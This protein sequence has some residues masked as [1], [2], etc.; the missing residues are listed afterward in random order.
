MAQE[1]RAANGAPGSYPSRTT[2]GRNRARDTR[3]RT[4]RGVFFV[5]AMISVLTTVGIILSLLGETWE[6]FQLV[7]IW[8]FLTET[9]WTPLFSNQQFGIWALVSATIVTSVIAL[10]IAVPLGIIAAIYL[11]EFASERAREILKPVLE[12]VAGIPTVVFGFFALLFVTPLLRNA[13]TDLSTFNSLSAGLVMGIMILPLVASL[14]E[15]AMA[16]VPLALREGA[17]GLGG[18]RFEVATRV[19]L[20]AALSGV[21]ASVILAASRAVGETMIVAIA[22]GQTPKFTFNPTETVETMTTYIVQV[23]LGDTP[24]GSLAY[25]TIFAVGTT[26]F[27]ITFAMN[28]FSFWF[29][30]KYREEYD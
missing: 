28:A 7:P 13:I 15:D 5:A 27:V 26:L 30:R 21:I 20:P 25:K 24:A 12:I 3:E 16:A 6:F 17:Y 14:S 23:S 4:I 9:E 22:A 19:V 10:L 2:L 29:V 18:T 1:A 8:R 11:S